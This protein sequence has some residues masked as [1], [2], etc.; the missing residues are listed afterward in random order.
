[1]AYNKMPIIYVW[2]AWY[3]MYDLRNKE[4]QII[5]IDQPTPWNNIMDL[6]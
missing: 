4:E 2:Y 6:I 3:V 1:M 5:R